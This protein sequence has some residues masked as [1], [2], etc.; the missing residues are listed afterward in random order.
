MTK[1]TSGEGFILSKL[2][3]HSPPSRKLWQELQAGSEAEVMEEHC[4]LAC[5]SH[6]FFSLLSYKTQ[7]TICPGLATPKVSWAF[8]LS[9]TNNFLKIVWHGGSCF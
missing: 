9:V 2:P 8:P 3:H 4:L 7:E 1:E 5:F 6:G